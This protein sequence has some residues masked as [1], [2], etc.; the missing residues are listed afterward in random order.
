[1]SN[2]AHGSIETSFAICSGLDNYL[3]ADSRQTKK[4]GPSDL[5]DSMVTQLVIEE[6]GSN[7]RSYV[8]KLFALTRPPIVLHRSI[9]GWGRP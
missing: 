3:L 4:L 9:R 8:G 2:P 6:T 5:V 7:N 1:M